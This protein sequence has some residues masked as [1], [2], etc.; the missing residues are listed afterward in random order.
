MG[1]EWEDVEGLALRLAGVEAWVERHLRPRVTVS[2]QEIEE[3]YR[4]VILEPMHNSDI[5][6]PSLAHVNEQLRL[7]VLEEK[8]NNEIERW[9]LQAQERHRVTRFVE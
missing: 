1:L 2:I 6:P 7:L 4:R 8:L 3:A 9:A 5:P